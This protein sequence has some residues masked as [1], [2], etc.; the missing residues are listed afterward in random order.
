KGLGALLKR[1]ARDGYAAVCAQLFE[2]PEAELAAPYFT[3]ASRVDTLVSGITTAPLIRRVWDGRHLL[4][5]GT[6]H[7]ASAAILAMARKPDDERSDWK[8]TRTTAACF[9]EPSVDPYA[10][11]R[12][13]TTHASSCARFRD[14]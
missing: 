9:H 5:A 14:K 3:M 7:G 6:S 11:D 12:F 8:G 1:Y 2:R 13:L 10:F 4:F